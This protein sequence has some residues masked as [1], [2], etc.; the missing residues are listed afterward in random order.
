LRIVTIIQARMN[1]TRLPGK[2]LQEIAGRSMLERVVER[3]RWA[4]LPQSTIIATTTDDG[5]DAIVEACRKIDVPVFR[6]SEQQVLDRYREAARAHRAQAVVRVTCDCPLVD[7]EVM[8]RVIRTLLDAGA[9]YASNTLQRTYPRGLDTEA[10]TM[11]A[12]ETAWRECKDPAA[13]VHVTPFIYG[14]PDRFRLESCEGEGNYANHRW[15]V[16]TAEDL[17]LIRE[18]YARL[19]DKEQFGWREVLALFDSDPKLAAMN[20]HVA[21]KNLK[22]G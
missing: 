7:A 18:I 14:A 2:V 6:G 22:D 11:N 10:F 20:A 15:T 12:L 8:D 3:C 17:E 19:G 21:Q 13:C 16:D 4:K 1:S 5:D 9:D